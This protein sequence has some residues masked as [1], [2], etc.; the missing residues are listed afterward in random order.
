[1]PSK[2][3]AKA[4]KPRTKDAVAM[5]EVDHHADEYEDGHDEDGEAAAATTA[6]MHGR[7]PQIIPPSAAVEL[8]LSLIHI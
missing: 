7:T 4:A 6:T 8:L 1:M 3:K 2:S 5:M